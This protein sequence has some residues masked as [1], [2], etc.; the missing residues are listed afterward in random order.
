MNAS[1][2]PGTQLGAYRIESAIGAGGM[3]AV[4]RA[5]DTRLG[6]AVALKVLHGEHSD[7]FESEA[8][9]IAALNH[10]NICTLYDVG[11]NYMVMEYLEGRPVKGPLAAERAVA[12]GL[13]I[14]SA[15]EAAHSKG[16]IHR[17][18]KPDNI[19]MT[20]SGV[21]L[22]DFGLARRN[23]NDAEATRTGSGVIMGTWAYMSPEQMA[24]RAVDA[25]SD[26]F[27]F[28]IVLFELLT[29]HRPAP[30]ETLRYEANAVPGAL[31]AVV[32]RCLEREP[33]RR[34]ENAAAL[35]GALRASLAAPAEAE[36]SV[37]VLP[38]SNL[39]ADPA[40]E[41]F[42]DGLAEEIINA[43]A[44]LPG[45]KVTARTSAFAFKGRNTDVREISRS[46]GVE[47]VLE[48]SVRTAGTRVRILAQ[49]S[50]ALNGLQEWSERYDREMT[51]IFAVQDEISSAV[52]AAL[53]MRL[54][55][56][57]PAVS[58]SRS[59]HPGAYH[60]YLEGNHHA[61]SRTAEGF[62]RARECFDRAIHLAPDYALPYAG[63][64]ELLSQA[65]FFTVRP[66]TVLP[67]AL[68][69]AEKAIQLDASTPETYAA[70]GMIRGAFERQWE[71]AGA[72]LDR[73]VD[74]NPS[75][76]VAHFRRSIWSQLQR[77]RMEDARLGMERALA[78]D[79][80]SPLVRIGELVLHFVRG[81]RGAALGA[82]RTNLRM[83]PSVW[84][85]TAFAALGLNGE[86]FAGEAL[87]ALERAR[88]LEPG[89]PFLIATEALIH[90]EQGRAEQARMLRAQLED[91]AQ[92][93][94]VSGYAFALAD[95]GSDQMDRVFDDLERSLVENDPWP[96]VLFGETP[97]TRLWSTP[98]FVAHPRRQALL[99]RMNLA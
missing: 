73:A 11:P 48:G 75:S 96:F 37:A 4:Y 19:L 74:L 67:A 2:E 56:R 64:A 95:S 28:G 44:R 97:L 90:G 49:L 69:A 45:M 23:L 58:R 1:L 10:P 16:I 46:L 47:H 59:V 79:P 25:R 35:A 40:N 91:I 38:F 60:A 39:T 14:V 53:E 29:G 32:S 80:L 92:T 94:Y 81:D 71:L 26:I 93:R 99:A 5:L 42:S 51:D 22:L 84:V 31:A 88:V 70:R 89:N 62:A 50:N 18:L 68:A 43:L 55:P 54:A 98:E 36:P 12:I 8:R 13:E 27:S 21:K 76:G 78:L 63:L 24:G 82:A 34:F 61:L 6:R 7:R 52:A 41:Y 17:D 3:G 30:G 77:G 83:F 66:Q 85:N 87:A 9:A 33:E 86:G 15:L 20:S 57:A 72:D 65:A